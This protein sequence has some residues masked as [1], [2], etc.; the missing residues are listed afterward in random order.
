MTVKT[1]T[2]EE[3][4]ASGWKFY[5]AA[6]KGESF[7]THPHHAPIGFFRYWNRHKDKSWPVA[8]WE[9]EGRKFVQ[10]GDA[11]PVDLTEHA[12]EEDFIDK[13]FRHCSRNAIDYAVYEHWKNNREWPPETGAAA[14]ITASRTAREE[15][16]GIGDNSG[17]DP[18]IEHETFLDQVRAALAGAKDVKIASDADLPT[19][20]GLRN[21]LTELASEGD[22][23]RVVEKEPHLTAS[24]AVDDRWNP[25]IKEAKE[26][27]RRI[28]AAIDAHETAKLRKRREEEQARIAAANPVTEAPEPERI[29]STYGKRSTVKTYKAATVTDYDAV[30]RQ[31]RTNPEVIQLLDKLA[32]K[33]ISAGGTL[34]G[35]TV[36]E[37]AA[38]R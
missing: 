22:K 9:H 26:G 28:K 17:A 19:A 16:A 38:I 37:R 10:V 31:M 30:F 11:E 12:A 33:V 5:Y 2:L 35:V 23:K 14:A 25:T 13:T 24:R 34:E 1:M 18:Q 36:E 29:E 3:S 32:Q 27:A 7:P 4:R 8:I 21:R 20:N 6:L 15:P